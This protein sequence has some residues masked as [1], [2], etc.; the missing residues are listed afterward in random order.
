MSK[1]RGLLLTETGQEIL[2]DYTDNGIASTTALINTIFSTSF[3]S[4]DY[5]QISRLIENLEP[6]QF[7]ED[8]QESSAFGFIDSFVNGIDYITITIPAFPVVLAGDEIT[9]PGAFTLSEI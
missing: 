2:D 1:H 4:A 7:G 5:G 3:D 9:T 6:R 8:I